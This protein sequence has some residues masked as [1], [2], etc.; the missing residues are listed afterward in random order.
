MFPGQY[1]D[2]ETGLHYNYFRYYDPQT[3]R[4]ITSDPI[5]LRGGL[6]SYSYS[7]GNPI[8]FTD[9]LGL[10]SRIEGWEHSVYPPSY[11]SQP[12]YCNGEWDQINSVPHP[13][14]PRLDC[15]CLWVCNS[16][17]GVSQGVVYE[18]DGAPSG[19]GGYDADWEGRGSKAK[20]RYGILP[21]YC[22]CPQPG[23]SRGCEP[24]E[25]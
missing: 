3:G 18:T 1:Y 10:T 6:N 16:C 19:M 7:E 2:S 20:P 8:L 14:W 9:P 5:G 11:N 23:E 22:N 15:K 21:S 17:N 4:Y 24:C 25:K 13:L 12:P